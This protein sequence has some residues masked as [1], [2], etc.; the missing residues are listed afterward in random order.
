MEAE[1]TSRRGGYDQGGG[2]KED[3]PEKRNWRPIAKEYDPIKIGS[4]NG[5][6]T[7]AHD[8]AV[9]RALEATYKPGE[10]IPDQDKLRKTL[11]IAQLPPLVAEE[12][13]ERLF[14]KFGRIKRVRVVRD[15]VTRRSRG[16]G[17]VEFEKE[18]HCTRAYDDGKSATLGGQPLTVD[19]IVSRSMSGWRPR[20]LGGGFGGS[21]NS[22]Q[23]RFGCRARPWLRPIFKSERKVRKPNI[24]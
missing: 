8:R 7:F 21:K 3:D 12:E 15:V 17:F 22:G 9:I 19:R 6:G 20:R 18:R 13:L 16:Y 1:G 4:I 10:E 23:L 2:D 5:I 24:Y 14:S 11:L